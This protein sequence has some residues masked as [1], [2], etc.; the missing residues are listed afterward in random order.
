MFRLGA[1]LKAAAD[2]AAIQPGHL[3]LRQPTY[4]VDLHRCQVFD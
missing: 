2:I 3:P 4:F 1:R